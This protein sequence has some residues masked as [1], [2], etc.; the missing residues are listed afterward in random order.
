MR[1]LITK[2][3]ALMRGLFTMRIWRQ[4]KTKGIL[5]QSGVPTSPLIRLIFK[6]LKIEVML[7]LENDKDKASKYVATYIHFPIHDAP[8]ESVDVV[9]LKVIAQDIKDRLD[10]GENVLIHCGKGR[11]RAS[12]GV[13]LVLGLYGFKGQYLVDYIRINRPG[14]LDNK[15]FAEYLKDW[16]SI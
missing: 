8:I 14:A 6:M 9:G 15:S 1:D 13:G 4:Y 12:L 5:Y 10:R 2:I 7:D 11:N 3:K 16:G